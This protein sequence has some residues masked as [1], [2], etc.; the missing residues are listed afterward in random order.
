MHGAATVEVLVLCT[1]EGEIELCFLLLMTLEAQGPLTY[2]EKAT[3]KWSGG[4]HRIP[5]QQRGPRGSGGVRQ[6]LTAR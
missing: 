4:V 6:V 5:L 2:T 1:R 3:C